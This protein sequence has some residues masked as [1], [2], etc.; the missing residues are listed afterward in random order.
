MGALQAVD[1]A[2]RLPGPAWV[3]LAGAA[4]AAA[5]LSTSVD[6]SRAVAVPTDAST[7]ATT[8]AAEAGSDVQA[9]AGA[10]TLLLELHD[11]GAGFAQP[12]TG[13]AP[14]DSVARYV[15]L[16]ET[17]TLDG[18]DLTMAVQATGALAPALRV[19]VAS[20]RGGAWS[21]TAGTCDGTV[22]TLLPP[23]PLPALAT[24][25]VLDPLGPARRLPLRVT[26]SLPDRAEEAVNGVLPAGTLQG[27]AAT[28]SWVFRVVQAS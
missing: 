26:L 22:A 11:D 2:S 28:L 25:R 21:T 12:V 18:R 17:G 27:A 19:S 9:Q 6:G 20:C 16:D 13:L 10:G 23:T 4:V 1:Q 5:L 8:A 14:G 24:A 3:P 7:G 15:E